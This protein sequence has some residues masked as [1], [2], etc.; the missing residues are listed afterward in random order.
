[1]NYLSVENISKTLSDKILFLNLN[2]GLSKGEKVALI[3][4]NGAGKSSL[5]RILAGKDTPD[6][7]NIVLRNSIKVGYLEQHPDFSQPVSIQHYIENSHSEIFT[8]LREYQ[9]ALDAQ[10]EYYTDETHKAFEVVSRRMDHHHAWDYERKMKELLDRF[11]IIDLTQNIE[12][13]SGGQKKRLALALVLLDEPDI[14]LLDEPT[15]HLD[16]EMIEW[17]EKQ[18]GQ[19]NITLLVV[20]HDRYFLDS[21]C[22]RIIELDQGKLFQYKGNYE[23]FLTKKEERETI[24]KTETDKA[25]QLMKKEL[26]W[27]RRMPKAR[28]TKSKARID[29][30]QDISE[31]AAGNKVQKGLNL[32]IKMSRVGGK[33]LEVEKVTK[34]FGEKVILQQFDYIFKKGERI[35]II[36]KNGTGKTTFVNLLTGLVQPDSGQLMKGDTTVFGY[37]TQEGLKVDETKRVID[38]V[39]EIAE[40]ITT[41]DGSVLPVSVFLHHFLFTNEMQYT[42][43][44]KLSGGEKRRL[45]LLTV[46]VKNPNFLILDEPTND[47]DIETLNKLEEFLSDFGGCLILVSH[48]RYF[49]DKLVDHLFIF[50]GEGNVV[51]YYGMYTNYKLEGEARLKEDNKKKEIARRATKEMIT[52]TVQ[53]EKTKL[54][55]KER[56]ELENL[57]QEIEKLE[58]QKMLLEKELNSGTLN[59]EKLESVSNQIAGL[60]E[61]LDQKTGRWLE[62]ASITN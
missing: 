19:S 36:G 3:A 15:N 28:T 52:E 35:G 38:V 60:I 45:H 32:E 37:Y 54:T 58:S 56:L 48:D 41:A 8:L 49:L 12:T 13:L 25:R 14:L 26:E 59:Y 10:S 50:N 24:E 6:T 40:V 27:L 22:D 34:K 21:V 62:L 5:L 20:T 57:E 16:I 31:K 17:L 46:L 44:S 1:M 30:F 33:I 29:A 23:F 43:V 39:K 53:K 51:D 2:F 55:Y 61:L 47:L 18:L 42:L 7:G 11:N 4:R 9:K